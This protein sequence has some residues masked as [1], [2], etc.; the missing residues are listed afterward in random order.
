L[1]N[2][3][4]TRRSR[5]IR[6]IVPAFLLTAGESFSC[7]REFNSV[8]VCVCVKYPLLKNA[9]V[10]KAPPCA[11]PEFCRRHAADCSTG[12]IPAI[13]PRPNRPLP[14]TRWEDAGRGSPWSS[15]AVWTHWYPDG[16]RSAR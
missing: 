10:L 15:L 12:G 16:R 1:H 11:K 13:E 4:H 8:C 3:H 5:H 14:G 7:R 9:R 2:P 6:G